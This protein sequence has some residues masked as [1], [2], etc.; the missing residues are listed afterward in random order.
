MLISY[1]ALTSKNLIPNYWAILF[2]YYSV[3][4]LSETSHLLATRIFT[5]FYEACIFIC[6]AQF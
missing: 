5:T 2:P 1:F 3:T 6:L 4:C